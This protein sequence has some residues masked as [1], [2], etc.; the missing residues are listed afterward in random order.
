M[1]C[2][3]AAVCPTVPQCILDFGQSS[4]EIWVSAAIISGP[5]GKS[6]L[7]TPTSNVLSW[8]PCRTVI[9]AAAG[10]DGHSPC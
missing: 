9:N 1:S 5:A 8:Q 4:W 6:K 7:V 3:S 2:L 10:V